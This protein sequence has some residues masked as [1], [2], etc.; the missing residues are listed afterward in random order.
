MEYFE[1]KINQLITEGNSRQKR[2]VRSFATKPTKSLLIKFGKIFGLIDIESS[3]SNI[4][5]LV[6]LI[7]DE[8]K[9][10]YYYSADIKNKNISEINIT[11]HFE[12]ALKKTNLS[13]A[14]FLES[15]KI[16]IDLEKVNILVAVSCGSDIN[17]TL[18]GNMGVI[19]LYNTPPMNYKIIDIMDNFS[20]SSA[21]VD[22]LKIFSQ[23]ISGKIRNKDILFVATDNLFDYFSLEKLKN[24]VIEGT[25]SDNLIDFK[26]TL[27][28]SSPQESFGLV[29]LRLEKNNL[30]AKKPINLK[31]EFDY[32]EAAEKDSIKNLLDTEK[33]TQKLLTPSIFPEIKKYV[34]ILSKNLQNYSENIKKSAVL[35]NKRK[36]TA[37]KNQSKTSFV[38]P[39]VNSVNRK[40]SSNLIFSNSSKEIK[41]LNNPPIQKQKSNGKLFGYFVSLVNLFRLNKISNK[42]KV[43]IEPLTSAYKKMVD[44]LKNQL[45]SKKI[46]AGLLCIFEF[47]THRLKKLPSSSKILLIITVILMILFSQSIIWIGTKNKREKNIEKFNQIIIEVE[48][49]KTNAE[50]SLI[51]RDENQ[52]R[53]LLTEARN[54]LLSLD[55]N[56]PLKSQTEKIEI[57][58]N[59]ITEKINEL[60]YAIVIEEPE[61]L[62]NFSDLRPEVKIGPF[63]F[64]VD[65]NFFVHDQK[66]QSILKIN[67]NQN[68]TEI[69]IPFNTGKISLAT[70]INKKEVF[71]LNE[72]RASFIFNLENESI[73]DAGITTSNNSNIADIALYGE[74]LYFL[75]FANSQ[76]YRYLKTAGGY[77]SQDNWVREEIDFKDA[78]SLAI[79]GS[80]Y[81]LKENGEIFQMINGRKTNFKAG[82]IDPKV[83]S[84][85]KIK[86]NENSKYLYILDPPEKRLIIIGKD[87]KLVNQYIS[88]KFDDLK[89][90]VVIE[91]KKEIYFLNGNTIFIVPLYH[92]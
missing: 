31:N 40:I 55:N 87:G 41:S 45:I 91:E 62:I 85:N 46:I 36:E 6:D 80:I 1:P 68:L 63:L 47:F 32:K 61:Q 69:K 27:E 38:P 75:D 12:E 15:E 65:G 49:K 7:I 72:S 17:L 39:E 37:A 88:D 8:I 13:I 4:D 81:I 79:D 16:T 20:G 26:K 73:S 51:Y 35:F 3:D 50:S 19:M 86:T 48:N 90:I 11:N 89:D 22:P 74:R 14:S 24:I 2:V 92:L 21:P 83:K 53:G 84:P 30:T 43:T 42:I 57:L 28:E 29:F 5:K 59:S 60:R 78:K 82:L 52:A 67:T 70:A 76:I 23:V 66:S 56:P 64:F 54:I 10:N 33:Q 44:F 25:S 9:N 71:L 34:G 77:G 18:T 58:L